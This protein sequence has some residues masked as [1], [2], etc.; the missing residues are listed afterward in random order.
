MIVDRSLGR[1]LKEA[2]RHHGCVVLVG[3]YEVGKSQ[4]ARHLASEFGANSIYLRAGSSRDRQRIEGDDGLVRNSAGKLIV[5]DEM[6]NFDSGFDLVRTEIENAHIQQRDVGQFLLL[7]SGSLETGKLAAIKLGTKALTFHLSPIDVTELPGH[8][9]PIVGD[10]RIEDVPNT[11]PIAPANDRVSLDTL[12]MR[13]GFPGSLL[14]SNEKDSFEWRRRYLSAITA[15]GYE[16]LHTALSPS[17]VYNF[18]ERVAVAQGQTFNVNNKLLPE[19][20]PCLDHFEDLGLVR[21]LKP[22]FGNQTKR[23]EK[24]PKIYMRDSGLLHCLLN[25]ATY[26]ELRANSA[27]G[28]SWEGFCIENLIAASK[29]YAR[30]F[31][32]RADDDAEIDLVL[33]FSRSR[34]CAIEIKGKTS[35]VTSGFATGSLVVGACCHIVVRPI[36]ESTDRSTTLRDAMRTVQS[37]AQQV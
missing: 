4:L 7:G 6:Q 26:D 35:K 25:F 10:T 11:V 13:G 9:P 14:A 30:P 31:F 1:E 21:R 33:E 17:S 20:R 22:W 27:F 3:P 36:P 19:Q 34:V 23:L 24:D 37:M 18:F 15:R 8:G 16:R 28:H 5:I 29:G 32:Y 12:W 2:L